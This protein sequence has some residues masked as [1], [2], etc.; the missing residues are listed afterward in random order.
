MDMDLLAFGSPSRLLLKIVVVAK[1]ALLVFGLRRRPEYVLPFPLSTP[2]FRCPIFTNAFLQTLVSS[3]LLRPH[4]NEV[5]APMLPPTSQIHV[6]VE[7]TRV[8]LVKWIAKRWLNIRQ[9]GEFDELEGWESTTVST[10]TP[11]A[12]HLLT[13][14]PHLILRT[15]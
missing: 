8:D 14:I 5:N 4:P 2:N 15:S 3:V 7:E 1:V 11:I 10:S 12:S 9:E 13:D 6:Q